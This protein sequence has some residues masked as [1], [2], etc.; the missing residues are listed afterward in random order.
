MC[1]WMVLDNKIRFILLISG[2]LY[3]RESVTSEVVPIPLEEEP[4]WTETK[5]QQEQFRDAFIDYPCPYACFVGCNLCALQRCMPSLQRLV[6]KITSRICNL[7]QLILRM[8]MY[9]DCTFGFWNYWYMFTAS[10]ERLSRNDQGAMRVLKR[11]VSAA[12]FRIRPASIA[13]KSLL[14]R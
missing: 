3:P 1:L 14:Q 8:T 10:I 13:L 9:T 12:H 2:S 11:S 5:I 7:C 4:M 6:T